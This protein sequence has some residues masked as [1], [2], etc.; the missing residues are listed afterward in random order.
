MSRQRLRESNIKWSIKLTNESLALKII[1]MVEIK[2]IEN[3]AKNIEVQIN[4]KISDFIDKNFKKDL[5]YFEKKNKVKIN[6]KS[7]DNLNFSEY[8]IEYK[9]KSNKVIEK[10]EKIESLKKIID[11]KTNKKINI[12][13]KKKI[14][15]KRKY[16][17]K[18]DLKKN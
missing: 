18:F 12:N 14:F 3:N 6:I 2:T 13:S 15:K 4:N 16:K 1:K 5:N 7:N 17:K 10:V 11:E 9:S 8:L